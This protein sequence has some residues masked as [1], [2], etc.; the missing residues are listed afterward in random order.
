MKTVQNITLV[1]GGTGTQ[2]D[3]TAHRNDGAGD[4]QR[5]LYFGPSGTLYYEDG[6]PVKSKTVRQQL[7]DL[8]A[9]ERIRPR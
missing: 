4:T 1:L 5:Q 3:W 7:R 9:E 8:Q 2:V 6:S